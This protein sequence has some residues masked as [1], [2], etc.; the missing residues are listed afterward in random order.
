MSTKVIAILTP[1]AGRADELST[2]LL[3]MADDCRNEPGN[4]RW[5][6]WRDA[7]GRFVL[8][9]LYADEA[10]VAAHR[11]T[12]HYKRYVA[13]IGELAERTVYVL[14]PSAIA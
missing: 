10:A 6:V 5:D 11:E 2:M 14:H 4:L 7:S 13:R 9:E 3:G 8:D 12:P 1:H